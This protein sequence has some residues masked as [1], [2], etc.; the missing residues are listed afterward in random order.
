M[1][2]TYEHEMAGNTATMVLFSEWTDEVLLGLR[3]K[4]SDAFPNTW[5][6][7]GG[8]LMVGTER[9]INAARRETLEETG[10]DIEESR[11]TLFYNDDVPCT[12]PRYDQVINLC[13]VADVTGEEYKAA[14]AD[15]DL[16]EVKW[17]KLEEALEYDLA[18]AHNTIL[19]EFC[20]YVNENY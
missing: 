9:L 1:T 16:D 17:V 3:E 13:Y 10:L 6:L 7:P 4:N 20:E 5:S 18:F 19:E 15:D 2:Y 14:K 12:D 11:W 8:Y